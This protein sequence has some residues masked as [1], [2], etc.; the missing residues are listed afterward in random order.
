MMS[1]QEIGLKVY[2][3]YISTRLI[4][5][6]TM[7]VPLRRQR[8]L[9]MAS[10]K[11]RK[12]RMTPQESEA[13]QVIKCLRRRLQWCNNNNISF[14]SEEEQY[15]ILPRALT[16]ED[17]CPHKSNKSNWTDKLQQCYQSVEPNVIVS[18]LPWVPQTAIIDAMFIINTRPLRRTTTISE[19]VKLLFNQHI[20]EHFKIGTSEVHVIFDNPTSQSFNPKMFEQAR[21]HSHKPTP[22]HDHYVFNT[23][24]KWVARIF[25]L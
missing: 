18:S 15:S 9:T 25:R 8:L 22:K 24:T 20:L 1:F 14:D 6:N 4:Q 10:T 17:G 7:S 5:S 23:D 19:Y 2:R 13:K 21:R 12:K 16:D 3:H 11:P